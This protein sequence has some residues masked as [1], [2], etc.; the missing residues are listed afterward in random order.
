MVVTDARDLDIEA[1]GQLLFTILDVVVGRYEQAGID[2]PERR[3]IH[4]GTVAA[5]CEQLT[6]ELNQ[7]FPGLPGE[8]PSAAQP[9]A[10][11]T[12]RTAATTVTI[13]RKVPTGSGNRGQDPPT[14]EALTATTLILAR[15]SW[16]LLDAA[17][18]VDQRGHRRGVI[19]EVSPIG[20][21]GGYT[22]V[23][24]TLSVAIA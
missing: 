24:M 21:S 1:V 12:P 20:P 2:L 16:L 11:S 7:V 14:P 15:D 3:Y 5:D 8:D 10:G 22:G 17:E 4:Y 23:T 18:E 6:V 9:C 19:A 13:F